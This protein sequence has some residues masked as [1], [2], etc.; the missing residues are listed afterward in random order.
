MSVKARGFSP[1]D[2]QMISRA[3]LCLMEY[4][5]LTEPQA[6]RFIQKQSM[7]L[8]MP[9][10]KVAEKIIAMYTNTV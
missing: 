2:S 4:L 9:Q 10:R 6:H 5:K 3:K 1:D 8:R 7:D